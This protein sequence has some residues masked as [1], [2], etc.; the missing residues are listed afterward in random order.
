MEKKNNKKT[1]RFGYVNKLC[2]K[3]GNGGRVQSHYAIR[4]IHLSGEALEQCSAQSAHCLMVLINGLASS[5]V[6]AHY[7]V[8]F[9]LSWVMMPTQQLLPQPFR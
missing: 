9:M 6:F 5:G 4:K 3:H 2:F 8:L 7:C 1:E